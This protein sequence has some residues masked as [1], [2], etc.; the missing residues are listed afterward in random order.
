VQTASVTAMR[1]KSPTDL[2]Y[3]LMASLPSETHET[4]CVFHAAGT[5]PCHS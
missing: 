5:I 3:S 4:P 2:M 1:P